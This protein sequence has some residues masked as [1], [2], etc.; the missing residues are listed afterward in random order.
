M[1]GR[2]R[3]SGQSTDGNC[4]APLSNSPYDEFDS[5]LL[6]DASAHR[7]EYIHS[8]E[9][10][11]LRSVSKED[12]SLDDVTDS[13]AM[14][15]AVPISGVRFKNTIKEV[16]SENVVV[17]KRKP[18]SEGPSD[19]KQE[20]AR[21]S[22]TILGANKKQAPEPVQDIKSDMLLP[23]AKSHCGA[24]Q[25]TLHNF[26]T[27]DKT[28]TSKNVNQTQ[29]QVKKKEISQPHLLVAVQKNLSGDVSAPMIKKKRGSRETNEIRQ[30]RNK[31][32]KEKSYSQM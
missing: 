28:P 25:F 1:Y 21:T 26:F 31:N 11:C 29:S 12:L 13:Y 30:M 2:R 14:I 16:K 6:G 27:S 15:A 22:Q 7:K 3:I 24:K 4:A 10:P 8:I 18:A 23:G 20:V 9:T 32:L 17:R 5:L 19:A